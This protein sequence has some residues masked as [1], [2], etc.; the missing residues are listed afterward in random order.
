MVECRLNF[1][2][3]TVLQPEIN[4]KKF[5]GDRAPIEFLSYLDTLEAHLISG[6]PHMIPL[7]LTLI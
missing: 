5:G 3:T 6:A 4:K 2:Y 7:L 1:P